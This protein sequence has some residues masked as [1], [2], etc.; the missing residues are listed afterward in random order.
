[1]RKLTIYTLYQG[2]YLGDQVKKD[3][4]GWGHEYHVG[5]FRSQ[6]K[7]SFIKPEI[8]TQI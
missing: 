3:N 4:F 7:V 5:G 6:D 2:Q 8:E 1:M